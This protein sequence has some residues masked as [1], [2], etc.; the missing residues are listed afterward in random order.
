MARRQKK[1]QTV[2]PV[3]IEG[4]TIARTFWGQ[5]W[6]DNLES[7]SDFANRLPRGR[8]YVR[9]GSVV[10]L[11]IK[12]GKIKATVSGSEL[13]EVDID[14]TALP[15]KAWASIKSRC[16]GQV[17][18]LVELLQGK[19]SKSVIEIVTAHDDGLFPTPREIHMSCSCPDWAGMC[20]HVAAVLYGVGARLDHQPELFFLLRKVDHLELIEEAASRAGDTTASGKK[21]GKSK[22]TLAESEV[23]GV[24]GI[25]LAEPEATAAAP[26][27]VPSAKASRGKGTRSKPAAQA[28]PAAP[29][30][31]KG[32]KG[33]AGKPRLE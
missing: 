33:A 4:R 10:D 11:Q 8:T 31:R 13:Y 27:P 26:T 19:L 24:F 21:A 28:D 23:A 29:K 20:K 1:G 12:P 17:G 14:V 3:V 18:S 15:A 16:M 22:K 7:Y 2:S 32:K 9:N 30:A 5:A 25:E 6:C